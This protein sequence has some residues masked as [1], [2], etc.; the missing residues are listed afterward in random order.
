MDEQKLYQVALSF[1]PGLGNL[2]TKNL[3]SYCGSA[4]AVFFAPKSKLVKF[5]A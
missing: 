2:L 3:I 4:K 1:I 5:R